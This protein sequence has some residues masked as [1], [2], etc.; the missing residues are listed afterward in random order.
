MRDVLEEV[1]RACDEPE[2]FVGYTIPDRVESARAQLSG[3]DPW[4]NQQTGLT[5]QALI[6]AMVSLTK[7]VEQ[8]D[9]REEA[10]KPKCKPTGPI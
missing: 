3:Q 6:R 9:T 2:A 8:W 5:R 7:A 4:L 1:E 10:I